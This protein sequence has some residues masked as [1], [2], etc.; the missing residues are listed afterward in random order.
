VLDSPSLTLQATRAGYVVT[1]D[2]R[3]LLDVVGASD[4][5]L[6][7]VP[8]TGDFVALEA[9]LMR[10]RGDWD[11][12][13]ADRVRE[14]IGLESER[15][16][17]QDAAFGIRQLVDIALRALSPGTNDPTTASQALDRVHDL[18]RRLA[19]R[20]F[21]SP[22]RHDGQGRLLLILPRPEWDDYLRLGLEEI[23]IAGR[24]QVQ[25]EERLRAVVADL[26]SVTSD[27]RRVA[28]RTHL[29]RIERP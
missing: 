8:R 15:T 21:P 14:A 22:Y 4:R 12:A 3:E 6:E 26:S 18:L 2:E 1:V 5:V 16:L 24:G 11:P 10:L 27:D 29:A 23:A 13:A 28:I 25:I 9:P 20:R 7:L 17:D 19:Q